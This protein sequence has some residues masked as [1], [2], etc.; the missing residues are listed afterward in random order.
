[1]MSKKPDN[2]RNDKRNDMKVEQPRLGRAGMIMLITICN[3]IAPLSTDMYMPALPDMAEYFHTS[4]A[5]MNITLVGFFILFAIGMLVFGPVSDRLG[6]RPVMLFGAI[7]YILASFACGM[8]TGVYFLIATRLL[9]ATGAGCMVAVSTAMVKDQFSGQTQGSILA[10][11]QMF[12]VLGPVVAPLLGA[13]IYRVFSWQ[14]DFFMQGLITIVTLILA[15][16]MKE[17]LPAEQRLDTGVLQT[18]GRLGKVLSNRT[19]RMFL[20]CIILIQIPM[21]AYIS[22]S[23]YIYENQFGLSSTGYSVYFAATALASAIGPMIYIKVRRYN[24][25]NVSLGIYCS[26]LLFGTGIMLLGH[27]MP[28]L[29]AICF[30]PVMMTSSVSRPFATTILLNLQRQ[31]SGSASSLSNF[32]FTLSGAVGMILITS[33]WKDYIL[34]LSMLCVITGFVGAAAVLLLRKTLGKDALSVFPVKR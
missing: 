31:D 30:A 27:I 19:F 13:Q 28:A 16:L 1:M 3:A 33:L 32:S 26:C 17:T 10:I 29:F 12:S 4:D 6:R 20:A 7:L 14:A 5:I 8:A 34:G 25:F 9:Q 22:S 21:M 2:K 11:A 24:P 18:F 23:S 15:L